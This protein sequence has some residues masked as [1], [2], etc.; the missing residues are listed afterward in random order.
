MTHIER[1]KPDEILR[2][3]PAGDNA[4]AGISAVELASQLGLEG[5]DLDSFRIYLQRLM[6]AGKVK[7]GRRLK[8]YKSAA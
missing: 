5:S 4:Q 3:I 8:L 1:V 6:D 7:V 2:R